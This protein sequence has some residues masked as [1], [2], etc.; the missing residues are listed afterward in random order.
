[1]RGIYRGYHLHLARESLGTAIYWYTYETLHMLPFISPTGKREDASASGHFL[2]GG[3]TGMVAWFLIFPI[4]L[5]KNVYQKEA[6]VPANKRKYH[7]AWM[8]FRSIIQ[9]KSWRGL[10]FGVWP[11][12]LRAFPIHAL[13]LF[14]YESALNFFEGYYS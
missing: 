8:C 2:A 10:W 4:D 9:E 1:M 6:V 12:M 7:G 11:T 3:L 14:I 5:V 13:N